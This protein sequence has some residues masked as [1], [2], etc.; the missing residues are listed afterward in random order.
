MAAS[1]TPRVR[2]AHIRDELDWLLPRFAGISF[3]TFAADIVMVRATERAL[4]IISE[5]AKALP[6]ELTTRYPEIEWHAIR[7]IGNILRHEYERVEPRILWNT[8]TLSLPRLSPVI[9]RMMKEL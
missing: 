8:L 2:L 5:A 1:K 3:E 9:D 4:L 7:G 6:E